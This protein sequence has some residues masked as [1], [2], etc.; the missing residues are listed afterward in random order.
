MGPLGKEMEEEEGRAVREEYHRDTEL[1]RW[2]GVSS[3]ALKPQ[4]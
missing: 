3:G 1:N 2:A 4:P